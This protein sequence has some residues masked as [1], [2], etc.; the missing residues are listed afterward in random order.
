MASIVGGF[1]VPH[2][3]LITSAPDAAPPDEAARVMQAFERV[4]EGIQA[5][6]ADTVIVIGD[7]HCAM[8]APNCHPRILIGVGD[9]EG[10]IE[11]W[12]RIGRT[13]VPNDT[14]LAEHIMNFGFEHGFDW[15]VAK[16]LALDHSTMVPI[17]LAVPPGVKCI[18][19]YISC[20]MTPLIQGKRCK[21][22]G[23]MIAR[24]VAAW[25]GDARVV[26]LGTGG[27]S[28]WVGMADMGRV[29]E[30]FDR[31]VLA[32]VE[33]ND[34][35]ALA[36]LSDAHIVDQAGNGAL[37]IRNW[38]VAMAAVPHLNSRVIAYEPVEEWVTGLGF[39]ELAVGISA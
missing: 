12:L 1:C 18:P 10:P 29:N 27:I 20:G 23:E 13:A 31:Q 19:V 22:L 5:L 16:S 9:L 7:D 17:H 4:R 28:H 6:R 38:I 15:A 32:L 37:E 39:T 34:V 25:P 35:E 30:E 36:V 3:P 2:D 24:A 8:F 14:P 11:P 21:Q 33:R 26:V